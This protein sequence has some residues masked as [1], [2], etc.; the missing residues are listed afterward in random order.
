MAAN[1]SSICK[2]EDPKGPDYKQV[3]G[4]LLELAEGAISAAKE[5]ERLQDLTV[6]AASLA[7]TK[8]CTLLYRISLDS[9]ETYLLTP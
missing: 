8:P 5:R 7:L 9:M 1:H 4:N 3:M 2:F 6:A